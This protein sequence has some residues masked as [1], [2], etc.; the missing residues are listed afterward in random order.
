MCLC[1]D[2]CCGLG[3]C[4]RVICWRVGFVLCFSVV[5]SCCV[6]RAVFQCRVLV[7]WLG[8][9]Y[10]VLRVRVVCWCCVFVCLMLLCIVCW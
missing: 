3:L 10:S 1:C 4:L 2:A 5:C 9:A 8:V 6:F 7:L